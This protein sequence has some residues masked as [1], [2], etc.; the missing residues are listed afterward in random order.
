MMG[1]QKLD[2]HQTVDGSNKQDIYS[3][4]PCSF[5]DFYPHDVTL[6]GYITL[7]AYLI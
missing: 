1:E 4:D 2:D 5:S 6:V 7:K 3:E